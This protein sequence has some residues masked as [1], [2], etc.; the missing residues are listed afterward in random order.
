M[1]KL[2]LSLILAT[3]AVHALSGQDTTDTNKKWYVDFGLTFS[4]FEQQIKKE[5]GGAKGELIVDETNTSVLLAGGYHIWSFL[6]VGLYARLDVG[7][8]F[9][10]R[11]DGFD[12]QDKTQVSGRIGGNYNE[13]WTG[14]FVRLHW[15]KLFISGGY[16]L[17]GIRTDDAR[18]DLP[19][20]E[21]GGTSGSTTGFRT[22]PVVAMV[23]LMGGEVDITGNL[24]ALF[25]LEYRI[26]Y[27]NAA[28][29]SLQDDILLG[30][31]NYSPFVGL[32]YAF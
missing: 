19:L 24:S 22:H 8:R 4:H 12:D 26:R 31:Q 3:I 6:S 13:F 25:A 17:F 16:G 7:K 21:S 28:S 15:K 30:T 18:D 14:P 1:K 9:N 27:Y 20:A 5:V 2:S 11:F 23:F 32:K 29:G 10:A